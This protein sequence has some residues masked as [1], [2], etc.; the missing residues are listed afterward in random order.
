MAEVNKLHPN[1][2]CGMSAPHCNQK[3][4]LTLNRLFLRKHTKNGACGVQYCFENKSISSPKVLE[5]N[6]NLGSNSPI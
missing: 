6:T 2:F 5:K 1:V 4:K 3:K